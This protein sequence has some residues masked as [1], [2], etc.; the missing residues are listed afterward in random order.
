MRDQIARSLD[1][2]EAHADFDQAIAA[3]ASELRG[4]RVHGL[5]H[6]AWEILEHLRIAQ[7]DI[8]D[9][10]KN[11]NYKEMKWP[12]EYWPAS[13]EP[14]SGK[15]WDESVAQFRRDRDAVKA[16]STDPKIDLAAQIPHGDKPSQTYL[17]SVLLVIDHNAYHVGE[18]VLLRRL[19]GAWPP[20]K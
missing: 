1:W 13:P 5:P 7:H 2:G 15:A 19:L 4:R 11:A 16:L 18:L 8:L 20:K 10:A 14:P 12:D 9:F 6:S 3:L 17:R